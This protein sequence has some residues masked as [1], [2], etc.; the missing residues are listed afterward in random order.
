MEGLDIGGGQA[1][2]T[3]GL[4]EHREKMAMVTGLSLAEGGQRPCHSWE[5]TA[6]SAMQPS[7]CLLRDPLQCQSLRN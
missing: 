6:S 1:Q 4:W 7:H 5:S 3:V 2:G